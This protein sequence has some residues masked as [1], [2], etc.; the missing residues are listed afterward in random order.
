MTNQITISQLTETTKVSRLSL[1][2]IGLCFLMML[3]DGYDTSSLAYAVPS[4]IH[5]A[6]VSA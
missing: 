6:F 4:L 3:A 1:R 5:R 2:V